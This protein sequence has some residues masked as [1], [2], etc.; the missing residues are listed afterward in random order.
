MILQSLS[1]ARCEYD[2]GGYKRGDLKGTIILLNNEAKVE[3]NLKPEQ[4]QPILEV[5][6]DAL[7]AQTK[8]VASGITREL[9]VSTANALPPPGSPSDDIIF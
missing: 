2:Y 3:L 9:V 1:I 6:A 8:A 7:V 4:L 5:V